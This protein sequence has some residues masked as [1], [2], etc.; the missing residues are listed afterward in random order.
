[1]K[2]TIYI[3]ALLCATLI[4]GCS[5]KESKTADSMAAKIGG[6]S[7]STS[8]V[9][10]SDHGS[11]VS[12]WGTG[13]SSTLAVYIDDYKGVGTYPVGTNWTVPTEYIA[14]GSTRYAVSGQVTITST[15]PNVSGTFYFTCDDN[16][17]VANGSFVVKR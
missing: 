3:F 5:K 9:T 2:T 14:N 7:F 1:M 17:R 12:I 4:G 10:F 15:S 6:V 8:D 11:F 16:T 13:A